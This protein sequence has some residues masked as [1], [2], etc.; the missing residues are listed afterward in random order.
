MRVFPW[1]CLCVQKT[2]I[3]V[4]SHLAFMPNS[5]K[6]CLWKYSC[7][8]FPVSILLPGNSHS[9]VL[10]YKEEQL[11]GYTLYHILDRQ[12]IIHRDHFAVDSTCQRQGIGKILLEATI[13][14]KP[15]M[16]AVT[17][18]LNKQAH[19]FYSKLGFY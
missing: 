13:Q 18:I 19:A 5:S 3:Q 4:F 2:R 11:V 10:A 17:R 1:V 14:S 16:I 7:S 8:V 12:A 9:L 6:S 15:E